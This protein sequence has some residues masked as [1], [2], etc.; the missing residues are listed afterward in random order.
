MTR[1]SNT[2]HPMAY[3]LEG[4]LRPEHMTKEKMLPEITSALQQV[5]GVYSAEAYVNHSKDWYIRINIEIARGFTWRQ[6]KPLL[7]TV[8]NGF[9]V[10][11]VYFKGDASVE[12]LPTYKQR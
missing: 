3:C 1:R 7:D 8:L 5:S 9:A 11:E 2:E 12:F 4:A 6:I 10:S